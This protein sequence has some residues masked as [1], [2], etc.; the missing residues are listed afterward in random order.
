M[1]GFAV[2]PRPDGGDFELF[3]SALWRQLTEPRLLVLD[4]IGT[5][6]ANE[7]RL[8]AMLQLLETRRGLPTIVTGN[9]DDKGIAGRDGAFD[10]RV[11]SRLT[12]GTWIHLVGSDRRADGFGKRS[13]RVEA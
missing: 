5:R 11:L 10:A 6:T 12:A 9:I 13:H 1:K 3:E 4:E 7:V 8:E 2:M